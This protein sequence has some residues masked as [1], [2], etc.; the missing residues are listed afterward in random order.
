MILHSRSYYCSS[1]IN[2]SMI[3][4]RCY[5]GCKLTS[6]LDAYGRQ[7]VS[8]PNPISDRHSINAQHN[9]SSIK[10]AMRESIDSCTSCL[11]RE[12][13]NEMMMKLFVIYLKSCYWLS[14]YSRWSS[15]S[16]VIFIIEV[17]KRIIIN[18]VY[19]FALFIEC[20][21]LFIF[22][23]IIIASHSRQHTTNAHCEL[24][25]VFASVD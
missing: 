17:N 1:G 15:Y 14:R 8:K 6:I 11:V 20:N 13:I 24:L 9:H 4:F 22:V 7:V 19:I 25:S 18:R 21:S 10:N 3:I 23:A 5:G 2:R 16:L 12:L